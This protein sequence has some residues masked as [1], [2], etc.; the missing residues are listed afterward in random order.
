MP[1]KAK[2]TKPAELVPGSQP[3]KFNAGDAKALLTHMLWMAAAS[4]AVTAGSLLVEYLK[5][6]NVGVGW[7]GFLIFSLSSAI[8]SVRLF[9]GD[10]TAGK[11]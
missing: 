3:G 4:G 7:V 9:M 11:S 5:D 1:K 6:N 2:A 8:K 10:T